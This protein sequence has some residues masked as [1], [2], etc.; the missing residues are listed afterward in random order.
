MM[1]W[2]PLRIVVVAP[3]AGSNTARSAALRRVSKQTVD[4]AM[5]AIAP[6]VVVSAPRIPS[7]DAFAAGAPAP[8]PAADITLEFASL[9]DFSPRRIIE[10]VPALAALLAARDADR[11]HAAEIDRA[12]SGAL[13][14]ILHHP[15]F[16]ALESAWRG[17]D[18]LVKRGNAGEGSEA[19]F[20]VDLFASGGADEAERYRAQVFD[21]D[22]EDR[23]DVPLAAVL[24]DADFDHQ[25]ASIEALTRYGQLAK[26]LQSPFI[27]SSG[28]SLF[29]LKHLAH[30]PALPDLATRTSGG[31]HAA[32]SA[33]LR[34][35]FARWLSLTTNRL[36]LRALYGD[37][38]DAASSSRFHYTERFDAAHPEWLPWGRA[39]WTVGASLAASFAEHGHCAACDGLTGKGAHYGLPTRAIAQTANTSSQLA[40]EILIDD[41]KAWDLVRLGVTPII[42]KANGDVAYFPFVGNIYRV[43]MGS[44]TIDQTL[45]YYLY[46]GQLSHYVLRLLPS[47]P[48]GSPVERAAW[49]EA[50]IFGGFSPFVGD[51]PG[52]RV[53]VV[54]QEAEGGAAIASIQVA[55]TFKLQEK[56]FTIEMGIAI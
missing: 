53:K 40:T 4:D 15:A 48:A 39:M 25:A 51:A 2:M 45:S 12:L 9:A 21:P 52:E 43:V 19:V 46:L 49:L 30:L 8:G 6:S 11:A 54:A 41:S 20:L 38:G 27:A 26:A 42:G 44:I 47:V 32:W 55:P 17:V 56:A 31:P 35:E 5:R 7:P 16:L 3:L 33:L 29:G 14:A 22:Y 23:S 37:G 24:A 36:L 50:Q 1:Y 28:A 34:E 10:R 18:F 13:D